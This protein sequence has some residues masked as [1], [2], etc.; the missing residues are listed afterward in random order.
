M[1]CLP[2]SLASRTAGSP[3]GLG[4]P[5]SLDPGQRRSR[6]EPRRAPAAER[7]GDEA[8]GER[9][10]DRGRDDS[11]GHRGGEVDGHVVHGAGRLAEPASETAAATAAEPAATAATA[12]AKGPR[13]PGVALPVVWPTDAVSVGEKC[14]TSAAP[15][16]P[17]PTPTMPP[18]MPMT[19]ASP[20][21][22]PMTRRLRQPSA[23][24]VPN[25]RTRRETADIVSRLASRKAATSTAIASHR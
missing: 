11:G 9:Q 6:A 21:T 17:S 10:Q 20:T 25:S 2:G 13:A 22:W 3:G 4:R 19:T 14:P 23:L 15:R 8:A 7:A 18:I 12:T 1:V 5:G 16:K 24:S